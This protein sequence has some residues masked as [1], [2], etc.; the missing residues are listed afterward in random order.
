MSVEYTEKDLAGLKVD[1]AALEH[2]AEERGIHHEGEGGVV[3]TLAD[4]SILDSDSEDELENVQIAERERILKNKK[5][6]G[7]ERRRTR[8]CAKT[9]TS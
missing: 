4:K 1:R 2:V 6:A 8:L 5:L 3:L 9:R 7:K